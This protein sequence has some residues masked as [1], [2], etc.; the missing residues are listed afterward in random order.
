[1]QSGSTSQE[2]QRENKGKGLSPVDMKTLRELKYLKM[3]IARLDKQIDRLQEKDIRVVAG[4]V[5]GSSKDFPYIEV[6][7]SVL[8]E[9]P[10]TADAVKKLLKI[11]RERRQQV[12]REII[13]TEQFIQ[14][15][16]D[17]LTRQIF[18]L[19]FQEG[20]RQ[21]DVA[22]ILHLEQSTISKRIS[23]YLKLS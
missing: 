11:K 23:A 14:N 22:K 3:E 9:E 21:K 19:C 7:T 20:K 8:M 5:K 15:I 1:M 16:P 4:K 13:E 2:S 10:V 6:R 12:E 18:E 17:S